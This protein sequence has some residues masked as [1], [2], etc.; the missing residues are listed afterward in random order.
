MALYFK[1]GDVQFL[2][3]YQVPPPKELKIEMLS[4]WGWRRGEVLRFRMLQERS[5][6]SDIVMYDEV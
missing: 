3:H 6:P 2:K 5:L 1:N 4:L